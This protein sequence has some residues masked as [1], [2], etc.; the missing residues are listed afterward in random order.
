MNNE[1]LS[2]CG[3]GWTEAVVQFVFGSV[4]KEHVKD[5]KEG[6]QYST[7]KLLVGTRHFCSL[8]CYN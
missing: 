4:L 6:I 8:M 3:C 7:I 1:A 2:C 5:G